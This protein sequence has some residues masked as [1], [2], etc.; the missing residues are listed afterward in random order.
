MDYSKIISDIY[1]E[2][3]PYLGKG[4]VADYI[5]ALGKVDPN[6]Y[7]IAIATV[8]GDIIKVGDADD[9]FSIQSISKVFTLSM[10]FAKLGDKLWDSVDVEPSGNPF[11]SLVQLEHEH[12]I[13][14]NPFINAGALVVTDKIL[15]AYSSPKNAVLD[16]VRRVADNDDIYYD[17]SV[18]SSEK[19]EAARN[20]AL[21]HFMQSFG[22]IDNDVD[23][24]IDVYCHHCALSMSSVD[25]AKAF[26]YLANHGVNPHNGENILT[27][28]Q[29][30]RLNS[31]M[32]T[33]GCY[34]E[35]GEFAFRVGLPG[36]SGVG[37]G[38][39]AIIPDKLSIVV[40]S[41]ELNNYGN[42]LVG[43]ETLERFTTKTGMSIF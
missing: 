37:G 28:S 42:S 23:R 19:E 5:P 36:K 3:K 1:E 40:W 25:L 27:K 2:V 22:N 14:R 17:K 41:P 13:P 29:S 38:I 43:V 7:G 39:V 32:L 31:L 15:G 18:A 26:L 12:G 33:C 9:K 20:L 30:K 34:D 16:F 11:N 35:S 10:A 4:K 21:S 8:D 6:K 24:L